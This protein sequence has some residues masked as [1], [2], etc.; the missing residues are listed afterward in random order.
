MRR[1]KS[2]DLTRPPLYSGDAFRHQTLGD[3]VVMRIIERRRHTF[4][5][6]VVRLDF[7]PWRDVDVDV[8][9]AVVSAVA[10]VAVAVVAVAVVAVAVAVVAVAVAV[11]GVEGIF[12]NLIT[13]NIYYL[14][15]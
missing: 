13:T 11:V 3:V 4:V 8:I 2:T 9:V 7:M 6:R 12:T 14:L 5:I 1:E 15:C 10:V